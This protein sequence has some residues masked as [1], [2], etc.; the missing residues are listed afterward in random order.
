MKNM[1]VYQD[2][3]DQ[4]W[5]ESK[6]NKIEYKRFFGLERTMQASTNSKNLDPISLN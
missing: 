1:V 6:D 4:Y 3:K 2:H 5:F